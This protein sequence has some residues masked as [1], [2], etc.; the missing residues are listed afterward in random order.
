MGSFFRWIMDPKLAFHRG[1]IYNDKE[2]VRIGS[3]KTVE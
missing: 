2:L 1:L 3:F